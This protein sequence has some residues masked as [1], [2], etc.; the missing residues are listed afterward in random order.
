MSAGD[1]I[2][3][4]NQLK[5]QGKLDEAIALYHQVIEINSNFAWAGRVTNTSC[6]F[7]QKLYSTQKSSVSGIIAH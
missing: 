5:R 4:A 7:K 6:L 1:P 2:K 3:K